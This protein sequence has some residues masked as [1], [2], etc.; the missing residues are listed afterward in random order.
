MK[1]ES[2]NIHGFAQKVK[3]M[4]FFHSTEQNS[5]DILCIQETFCPTQNYKQVDIDWNGNIYHSLSDS[6]HSSPHSSFI[7]FR[8]NF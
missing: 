4:T 7:L 3:R 6:P 8:D 5:I 2:I 1:I